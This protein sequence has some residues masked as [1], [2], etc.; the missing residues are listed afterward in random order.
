MI[1]WPTIKKKIFLGVQIQRIYFG[2]MRLFGFKETF[3]FLLN[4]HFTQ[5]LP[6]NHF[7]INFNEHVSRIEVKQDFEPLIRK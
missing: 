5:N 3:C 1:F 4:D 6:K 2:K 7:V